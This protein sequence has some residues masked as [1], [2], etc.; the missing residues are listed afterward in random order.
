MSKQ[1]EIGNDRAIE[2]WK[3][4]RFDEAIAQWEKVLSIDPQIAEI[5]HNLGKAYAHQNL[6]DKAIESLKHAIAIDPTLV[7]A[8]NKLGCIFYDQGNQELAISSWNEALKVKPDFREALHNLHL[9]ESTPEFDIN[10]EIPEY[11]RGDSEED[12]EAPS[13][14]NRVGQ[15][16]GRL[17][18]RN[19]KT[20]SE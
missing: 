8:Y 19:N 14:L 10:S 3:R 18:G 5:H 7:E 12:D 1:A 20:D 16:I 11:E 9:A 13:W 4:D 15:W 2:Y 17:F 6:P